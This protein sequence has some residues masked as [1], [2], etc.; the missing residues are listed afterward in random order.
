MACV[1]AHAQRHARQETSEDRREG[2]QGQSQEG[3]T[4][5]IPK[6]DKRET[7]DEANLLVRVLY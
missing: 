7:E 6:S 1:R 2:P 3:L 5:A 4:G